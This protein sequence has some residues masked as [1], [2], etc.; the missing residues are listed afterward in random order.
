MESK[1]N[2]CLRLSCSSVMYLALTSQADQR[3]KDA[4][5]SSG[6]QNPPCLEVRGDPVT[7]RPRVHRVRPAPNRLFWSFVGFVDLRVGVLGPSLAAVRSVLG[8]SVGRLVLSSQ[9]S[10]QPHGRCSGF[11]KAARLGR[12]TVLGMSKRTRV[13]VRTPSPRKDILNQD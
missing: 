11:S 6:A 2:Q 12:F 10:P 5:H 4:A 1:Q 13:S 9:Q 3:E 8:T 7:I